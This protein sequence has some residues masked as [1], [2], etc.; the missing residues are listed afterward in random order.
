MEI[1]DLSEVCEEEI[2]FFISQKN[3]LREEKFLIDQAMDFLEQERM[4]SSFKYKNKQPGSQRA[5]SAY[6]SSSD[7]DLA[8]GPDYSQNS[9]KESQIDF[10]EQSQLIENFFSNDSKASKEVLNAEK[11][12]IFDENE[13]EIDDIEPR[14]KSENSEG[15]NEVDGLDEIEEKSTSSKNSNKKRSILKVYQGKES[16]IEETPSKNNTILEDSQLS[17]N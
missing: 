12:E 8:P 1:K 5:E 14:G 9:E 7:D 15:Q 17:Q 4:N 16:H 6:V 3:N 11:V 2:D 10:Q 13:P